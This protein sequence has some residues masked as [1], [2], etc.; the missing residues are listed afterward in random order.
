VEASGWH[1]HRVRAET[2]EQQG[3]GLV[4]PV[5]GGPRAKSRLG[6]LAAGGAAGGLALA[7]ALDCLDAVRGCPRVGAV[8]VVTGDPLVAA[9]VRAPGGVRVV[10]DPGAGLDAAAAAG[11]AALGPGRPRA[12]LLADLPC[13]RPHDLGAALDAA[14]AQLAAGRAAAVVPDAAGTGTV[15]LAQGPGP[16]RPTRFGP[17]SAAAHAADGAV[18]L[19]LALPRLRRDVDTPAD[20]EAALAL[21][22]GPATLAALAAL[23]GPRRAGA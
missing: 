11:L 16:V 15:L 12:V 5:K 7:V 22:V 1:D 2:R 3:W 23:A 9:A 4:L 21:G 10:G 17:G 19:E 6:G 13:L 14:D 8:V 20:L 18:R